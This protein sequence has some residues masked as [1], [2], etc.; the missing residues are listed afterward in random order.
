MLKTMLTTL[1]NKVAGQK[2]SL[3]CATG[4]EN[5]LWKLVIKHFMGW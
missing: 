3:F 2:N 4:E 1:G 5:A